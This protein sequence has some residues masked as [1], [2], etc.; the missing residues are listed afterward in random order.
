VHPIRMIAG[1]ATG[2][3]AP[4]AVA[5]DAHDTLYV[6]NASSVTVYAPNAAGNAHPLRMIEAQ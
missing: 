2:L 3:Q 6:V 1:P 4:A 5:L